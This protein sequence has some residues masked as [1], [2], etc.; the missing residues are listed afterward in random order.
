M[1]IK[2]LS[3][4]SFG[5]FNGETIAIDDHL[6]LIYG[7]N[8]AGKSTIKA[9]IN[10]LF[11]GIYPTTKEN[12][13]YVNWENNQLS[14]E[15]DFEIESQHYKVVRELKSST[16]GKVYWEDNYN[17]IRNNNFKYVKSIPKH[18]Y[19]NVFSINSSDLN[20]LD[21]ET[22]GK[23]E[24]KL[25]FSYDDEYILEPSEVLEQLN[26]ELSEQW[27]ENNKGNFRYKELKKKL[28]QLKTK[29]LE[30]VK[31]DREMKAFKYKLDKLNKQKEQLQNEKEEKSKLIKAI[32]R[33][34]PYQELIKEKEM[35]DSQLISYDLYK[36]IDKNI[37]K[38][39]ENLEEKIATLKE[40]LTVD[41]DRILEL[42]HSIEQLTDEQEKILENEDQLIQLNAKIDD[43]K[44][45]KQNKTNKMNTL[46]TAE[47]KYGEL[48][49]KLFN[50][51]YTTDDFNIL[52]N[53]T[54]E[55]INEKVKKTDDYHKK[56]DYIIIAV[57]IIGMILTF[58]LNIPLIGYAMVSLLAIGLYRLYMNRDISEAIVLDEHLILKNNSNVLN[59][60]E[61]LKAQEF[62]IITLKK[63]VNELSNVILTNEQAIK[64]QL[65][66]FITGEKLE[67]MMEKLLDQLKKIKEINRQ[68]EKQMSSIKEIEI[69]KE[70]KSKKIKELQNQLDATDQKIKAIG[71]GSIQ[72]GLKIIKKNNKIDIAIENLND[73]LNDPKYI[74]LKEEYNQFNGKISNER[75]ENLREK[76]NDID[77]AVEKINE[78][79]IEFNR[80]LSELKNKESLV[81]IA[82]EI[83]IINNEIEAIELYKDKMLL[84]REI[85][86]HSNKEFKEENQPE[87]INRAADYFSKFTDDKYEKI[88]F[89]SSENN[90]ISIKTDYGIKL[91]E[92]PFSQ[93]TKDQLYLALRLGIIDFYED[94]NNKLPLILDEIFV[95]WDEERLLNFMTLL[96]KISKE[97]QVI[98]FTCKQSLVEL[99]QTKA[100]E[101]NLLKI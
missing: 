28:K 10:T 88:Y 73:K 43:L 56:N 89:D 37:I 60:L 5:K 50:K 58:V 99:F 93:G 75:L 49:Y 90:S 98:I 52:K 41:H 38:A 101:Y 95:N 51:T 91:L 14:I 34:L 2:K 21:N 39:K 74:K 61:N 29:K 81:D 72:E 71:D 65:N 4:N 76:T 57:A 6:N 63:E 20:N 84:M 69:S 15:G 62:E 11:Y 25:I 32:E 30:A 17:N 67:L 7:P 92:Q 87:I 31:Y 18:I 3:L 80:K 45:K 13:D 94:G 66:H 33:L 40:D 19:E 86:S 46:T 100:I 16:I 82:T 64:D 83:D 47:K 26:Q 42:K 48:F 27:K 12:N 8:E 77:H 1:R 22:W 24:N 55:S 59:K 97:R 70:S 44:Y 78:E 54:M 9:A 35:Y 53:I 96:E 79:V 36:N 23:I 68:N 85:I